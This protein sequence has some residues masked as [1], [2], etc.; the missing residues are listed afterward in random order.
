MA[1]TKLKICFCVS[2][3]KSSIESFFFGAPDASPELA[4]LL[5][6]PAIVLML[7]SMAG[8]G[9]SA[10]FKDSKPRTLSTMSHASSL[11]RL[12]VGVGSFRR[13]G[14]LMRGGMV[15]GE[16]LRRSVGELLESWGSFEDGFTPAENSNFSVCA[17]RRRQY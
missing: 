17:Y 9:L 10:G 6:S 8:I 5:L 15:G 7:P 14:E 16:L 12:M 3:G 1:L 4:V 13:R 11:E 2:V